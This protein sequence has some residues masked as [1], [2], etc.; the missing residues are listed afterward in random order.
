MKRGVSQL[1]ATL[2]MPRQEEGPESA[3][4][5]WK[6]LATSQVFT[7]A[8]RRDVHILVDAFALTWLSLI[9]I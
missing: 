7:D 6:D 1:D 3:R 4:Y 9:H 5:S 2:A 8:L